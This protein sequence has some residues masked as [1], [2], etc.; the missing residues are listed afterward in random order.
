MGFFIFGCLIVGVIIVLAYFAT[1]NRRE[2]QLRDL[3]DDQPQGERVV[4]FQGNTG[5]PTK[6]LEA[7]TTLEDLLDKQPTPS[8]SKA[9]SK[10]KSKHRKGSKGDDY[11]PFEEGEFWDEEDREDEEDVGI[12]IGGVS[13]RADVD[14]V[15]V[16]HTP[17]VQ[18]IL[19]TD[20][21][22]NQA[23]EDYLKLLREATTDEK[24]YVTDNSGA[25][26]ETSCDSNR[27]SSYSSSSSS[28]YSS[29][30]FGG[31]SSGGGG[32]GSSYGG[33]SGGSYGSSSSSYDSSDSGSSYS[34][35]SDD[36]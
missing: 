2:Q 32:A 9:S 35:S 31:G 1:S 36:D 34:S 12:Q 4:T 10:S 33:G 17:F 3:V 15:E 20:E 8:S 18:R 14:E 6:P 26:R 22:S 7:V 29:S 23:N 13:F 30:S 25:T 21:E 28:S 24:C 27:S 11:D 16:N 5:T 19:E